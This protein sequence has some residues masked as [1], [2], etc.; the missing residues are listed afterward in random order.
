MS[1]TCI[2]CGVAKFEYDFYEHRK[3]CKVCKVY[4]NKQKTENHHLKIQQVGLVASQN[5]FAYPYEESPVMQEPQ[6]LELEYVYVITTDRMPTYYKIGKHTGSMAKLIQRY[7]T[8]LVDVNVIRFIEVS[9]ALE[10]EG[11]IHVLLNNF[12][13]KESEWYHSNEILNIFDNYWVE[14]S[15]DPKTLIKKVSMDL[16]ELVSIQSSRDLAK[17]D[18]L[19]EKMK[20][21]IISDF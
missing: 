12:R 21:L 15:M 11:A 14:L 4:K 19:C 3:T 8:A 6:A 7:R 16:F 13:Y 9:N 18:L 10:H 5:T 20:S 17:I 2:M 1:R